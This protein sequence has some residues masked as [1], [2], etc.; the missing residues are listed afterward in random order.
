MPDSLMCE[1][2]PGTVG[3]GAEY[4]RQRHCILD[5]RGP[6]TISPES[7]WGYFI[8]VITQSHSV[9]DWQGEGFSSVA[10]SRPVTVDRLAWICSN[11]LLYNCH[12]G[13]GAIVAFGAVVRSQEVKPY[14][15]VAGNPARVVA[16][17]IEGKWLYNTAKWE[18]LE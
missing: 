8:T 7:Y 17:L 6:L 2:L 18:V 14:V 16:R 5:C 12:I 9:D 11:S 13:E 15:M 4:F 3:H 1:Q 10:I